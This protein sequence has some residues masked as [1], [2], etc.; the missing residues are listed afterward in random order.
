MTARPLSVRDLL[1][2]ATSALG[3]TEDRPGQ[4]AMAEAVDSAVETGRHL[5][6]QAGTGT[7]KSLGYLVPLVASGRKAVI[8]TATK[9]LQDQLAH[10]DLPLVAETVAPTMG[11]DFEWAVLKGRSNYVCRQRL[12]EIV[13]RQGEQQMQLE[14]TGGRQHREV[15]KVKEWADR[16][17]TG[18]L[19]DL[20]F[21]ISR[22]TETAVTVG[23]DE[24][25]GARRCPLG[26]VCFAET[27]RLRA[28]E[29]DIV[30][31]NTHL[32]GL[33]V[34]SDGAI[35]TEHDVVVVD[36]A[37][38]LEDIISDTVAVSFSRSRF[39]RLSTTV[40]RIVDDTALIAAVNS[41]GDE[42]ERQL[43]SL[44]DRRLPVPLPDEIRDVLLDARR[45]VG[46]ALDTLR[47]VETADEDANQRRLRAQQMSTR[48]ADDLDV[49]LAIDGS[50][51]PFVQGAEGSLHLDIAPLDVGPVLS[52]S[53]WSRRTAI[54]TSATVPQNLPERVG[55]AADSFDAL[56]V[57]SPFDYAANSL[58]YCP[59]GFPNPNG[60][61][62]QSSVND[63]L[64]RL[65][66]AA[67]GRTLALF[68]SYRAMDAAV[69]A[70]RPI[71]DVP[72][73]SQRDQSQ[74]SRLVDAF[75]ADES[76]CL[77]ATAGF[78]QGIDIP[79]RTLSLVTIDRI[80][81]PRPDDPLL[82]ARRDLVGDRAFRDI[83]LPR[84]ATLLA[85]AAGRLIRST[86]D[87][88]VVAVFD[89][90]L[91]TAGYRRHLLAAMPPMKRTIDRQEVM[92]FLR[93]ID[94]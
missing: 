39:H 7:G 46:D 88:G 68:T 60:G 71:L 41:Q 78:F 33:D 63:E 57:G 19:A 56:D 76:A 40:A 37:H 14:G 34:A 67:R 29:A 82:S 18:D 23:A 79:G 21:S 4:R 27:A 12:E 8:T 75:I 17:D 94:E 85:Q 36:E 42:L 65:I 30:V 43:T 49:A 74:K 70:L 28:S 58:L 13:G 92:D 84:A 1:D 87:R 55:L 80:P 86:T 91:A 38:G 10:K 5:V 15:A 52:N 90:R 59:S 3:S 16:H 51:V 6:V 45:I 26:G 77:F 22:D 61:A 44:V 20:P 11:R 50:R 48:L 62:F 73:I 25:P 53:I 89:P 83:D 32:Y 72:V 35:L 9:A 54:L 24:C 47:K 31:V 2:V 64:F 66:T 69:E 81:F 93:S